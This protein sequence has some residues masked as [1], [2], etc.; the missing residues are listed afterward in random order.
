M[1]Y[2]MSLVMLANLSGCA[3]IYSAPYETGSSGLTYYM[4]NRDILLTITV[5]KGYGTEIAITR[6]ESYPDMSK[7]YN[8]SHSGG[9][10]GKNVADV[11]I[12][13]GLIKASKSTMTSNVNDVFKNA[14]SSVATLKFKSKNNAPA[15]GPVKNPCSD[16][17]H[18]FRIPARITKTPEL[19]CNVKI[20]VTNISEATGSTKSE[21]A[22]RNGTKAGIYYRQNIPFL[23]SAESPQGNDQVSKTN[24]IVFSPSGSDTYFLP[25]SKTFFANNAADFSFED[26]VPTSYKQDTDGEAIALLKLPADIFGAYFEAIGKVFDAFQSKDTKSESAMQSNLALE[27]MKQKYNNC[28]E[29]VQAGDQEKLVS[30]KCGEKL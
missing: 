1:K 3:S 29:A 23:I 2:L 10:F 5:E 17:D 30:L 25:I 4:P 15:G 19:L 28:M 11:Q 7:V 22:S 27:I 14:A 12:T 8:L 16:G 13:Q 21:Y 24:A 6:S 18:K 20:S 9:I 26:G